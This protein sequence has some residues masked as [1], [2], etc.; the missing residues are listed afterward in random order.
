MTQQQEQLAASA[1]MVEA[2]INIERMLMPFYRI[3]GGEAAVHQVED[4]IAAQEHY[5]LL[6]GVN[7][8]DIP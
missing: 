6:I 2:T 8:L 5:L 4:T 1:I 3:F 7:P